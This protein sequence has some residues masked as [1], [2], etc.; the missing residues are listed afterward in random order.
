MTTAADDGTTTTSAGSTAVSD[1]RGKTESQSRETTRVEQSFN[2]LL[3]DF[4]G[5][6]ESD[7]REW[8]AEKERHATSESQAAHEL[9]GVLSRF[10]DRDGKRIRPALLYYTYQACRGQSEDKAM[11]MAMA[12]ELL[13]TYLLIHDDIMDRADT[14]RG[15]PAVHVLFSDLHQSWRWSGNSDHFGESVAILVGDLAESYAMELFSSVEVAPEVAVEFRRCFSTMCQEV[16]IGQYLEMTAGYRRDLGEEELLRVLQ[17]KS[18][19]YSVER[20]V[21]LG[22][23]LARAPEAMRRELTLYGAKIGEAFQLQDD[24]LGMFGDAETV[25]KPVGSD[26]VEGKFTVLI[27]H[28]LSKLS[29]TEGE[30]LLAALGSPGLSDSEVLHFQKLI[31]SSGARQRVEEMIEERMEAARLALEGLDL[32]RSGADFLEGM[33]D[34]L[35]GRQR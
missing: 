25:G 28:T 15:E 6:L 26:L 2:S 14:R 8:L 29:A 20:P 13:H 34:Y 7:L 4:R 17:M 32:E 11:T 5:R 22:A 18:G 12:A 27:H 21:Q 33:I 9:T 3:A 24:L 35:R 10:V 23:L 31:E 19:R 16:I 1:R 30:S